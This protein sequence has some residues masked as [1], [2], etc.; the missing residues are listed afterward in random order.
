MT[1]IS[2][3]Q[4]TKELLPALNKLFGMEY[5]SM[6]VEELKKDVAKSGGEFVSKEVYMRVVNDYERE[7]EALKDKNM[8]MLKRVALEA[9]KDGVQRAAVFV[10]GMAEE[11][12]N[13][14]LIHAVALALHNMEIT[15]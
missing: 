6:W 4:L 8:A 7:I 3:D 15:E 2:R 13:S 10:E 5:E 1:G 12:G 9:R 14:N 11:V